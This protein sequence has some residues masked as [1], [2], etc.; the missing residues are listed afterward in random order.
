MNQAG[1]STGDENMLNILIGV[2]II[3]GFAFVVFDH[4]VRFRWKSNYGRISY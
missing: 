3:F 1:H 2:I 4:Y